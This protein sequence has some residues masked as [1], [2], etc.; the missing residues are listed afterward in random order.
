[1]RPTT[2]LALLVTVAACGLGAAIL[3]RGTKHQAAS[4]ANSAQPWFSQLPRPAAG[5]AAVQAQVSAEAAQPSIQEGPTRPD[6]SEQELTIDG[7]RYRI[8]WDGTTRRLLFLDGT[9]YEECKF[10]DGK[11]SGQSRSWHKG[12]QLHSIGEWAKGKREGLWKY[13]YE[14]GQLREEGEY[15]GNSRI[16]YW[17][18][19]YDTGQ[20]ESEGSYHSQ[21]RDGRWTY[22][23]LDGERDYKKSGVYAESIRVSD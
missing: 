10:E 14:N 22:W 20:P 13:Y 15:A 23:L 2:T 16:G 9:A 18:T 5:E 8:V 21:C 17:R 19:W 4:A 12:G 6:S 3:L 11:R 7:E 1:M